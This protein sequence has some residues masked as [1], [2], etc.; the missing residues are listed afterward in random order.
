[1]DWLY[2]VTLIY[3][4]PSMRYLALILFLTIGITSYSQNSQPKLTDKDTLISCGLTDRRDVSGPFHESQS[5][6]FEKLVE[7]VF[8]ASNFPK[9]SYTLYR[10]ESP[11]YVRL[12][13]HKYDEIE[14]HT[15]L[16]YNHDSI[17]DFNIKSRS[18]YGLISI[19]AHEVGHHSFNHFLKPPGTT[20]RIQELQADFFAGWIMATL[21]V[22]R[23]EIGKGIARV[24]G[25]VKNADYPALK[26]RLA[27][28]NLGFEAGSNSQSVGP[29]AVLASAQTL[30]PKWLKKWSRVV[31]APIQSA[32]LTDG[33]FGNNEQFVLDNA[34]Q[35]VYRSSDKNFVV[36]RAI[37]S[38]DRNFKY[39]LFDNHFNTWMVDRDGVIKTASGTTIGQVNIGI[40]NP[41]SESETE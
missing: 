15:F 8:N 26:E 13:R 27:A 14:F 6:D 24:A 20:I 36:G 2:L 29:L 3:P 4:D 30:D 32:V 17:V 7:G 22:P 1:M 41:E 21:N 34:G 12:G 38:K 5:T 31:P 40:L 25:S 28:V 10:M 23:E 16:L 39:V 35:L 18:R 11:G 9:Q 33:I 19:L 37:P